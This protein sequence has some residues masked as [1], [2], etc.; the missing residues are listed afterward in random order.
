MWHKEVTLVRWTQPSGPLCLWQCF[1]ICELWTCDK[2]STLGSILPLAMFHCIRFAV[3][4]TLRYYECS[5]PSSQELN[6]SIFQ[7]LWVRLGIS[8]TWLD[9]NSISL[10]KSKGLTL[11][12][13][14]PSRINQPRPITYNDPVSPSTNQ[15][16]P[17]ADPVPSSTNWYRHILTQHQQVTTIADPVHSF[18]TS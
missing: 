11:N 9:L 16:P 7:R 2:N 12:H 6:G 3:L 17:Y 13:P 5:T 8:N 10:Y 18:I 14:V 4:S 1:K 15:L